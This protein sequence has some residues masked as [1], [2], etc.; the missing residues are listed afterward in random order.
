MTI[1]YEIQEQE[2]DQDLDQDDLEKILMEF[3]EM[4]NADMMNEDELCVAMLNYDTNYT[5]KQ[6]QLICE[7]YSIKTARFKKNELIVKILL[8]ENSL[9]NVELVVR[10]REMWNYMDELKKDKVLRR[11]LLPM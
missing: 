4:E 3:E 9:E 7:Y 1:N 5:V 10:R 11:F 6:L 8:F 2:L